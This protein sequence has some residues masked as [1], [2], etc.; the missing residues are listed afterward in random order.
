MQLHLL[1]SNN[2][3][4]TMTERQQKA[5]KAPF[6]KYYPHLSCMFDASEIIFILHMLDIAYIR[7]KGYNTVWSKGHLMKRMNIRLR[8]FDRCVKRMVEM[9][10]L[11]RLP[12]DGMYDYLWNTALY[13][14]LLRIM[15]ATRDID[16]LRE[17]CRKIFVEQK[18]SIQ[19][20]SEEEI[21]SLGNEGC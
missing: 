21:E 13:N 9:E 16:R 20:V 5:P 19:S 12:Q 11:D 15:S 14:R 10:L 4:I 2:K 8:T 7:S 18:R 6:I 17:F 1:F 3:K